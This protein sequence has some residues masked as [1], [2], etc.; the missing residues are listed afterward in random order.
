MTRL[1][2]F[3]KNIVRK[4]GLGALLDLSYTSNINDIFLWLAAQFNTTNNCIELRNGFKFKFIDSVVHTIL[5]IPFGGLPIQTNP[6][7]EVL[8]KIHNLVRSSS[9]STELLI[10]L[11]GD[12]NTEETFSILFV[13]LPVSCLLAPNSKGYPTKKVYNLLANTQSVSN[14]NWC[15][16]ALSYL[17]HHIKKVKPDLLQKKAVMPGGCKLILVIAH[18]ECLITSEFKIPLNIKPRLPL[19]STSLLK[20]FIA[21]DSMHG[22]KNEFGRLPMKHISSTPFNDSM[23]DFA[24]ELPEVILQYIDNKFPS[25]QDNLCYK[26]MSEASLAQEFRK[27]NKKMS[28]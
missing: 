16:F 7:K 12:D 18:F 14:Y 9:P 19:W 22:E 10:S 28:G 8:E 23:N 27:I 5:G 21:L 17:A 2:D 3:Q 4:L 13:L 26:I 24:V 20:S 25:F 11:V 15:S 6:S 1:S